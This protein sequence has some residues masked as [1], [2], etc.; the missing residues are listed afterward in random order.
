[1][2]ADAVW[3]E[4]T[5]GLTCRTRRRLPGAS[6]LLSNTVFKFFREFACG[7]RAATIVVLGGCVLD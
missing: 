5:R 4:Q 7:N 2:R 6:F 3:V 1:M